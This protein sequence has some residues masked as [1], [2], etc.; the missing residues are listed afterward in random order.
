VAQTNSNVRDLLSL[1]GKVALITGASGHLGSAMA[2]ALAEA[3]ASVV[4]S[5]RRLADAQAAAERLPKIDAKHY[6]AEI[7]HMDESSINSGLAAALQQAGKI[8]VLVN[9]GHEPVADDWSTITGAQFTRQ[10]SNLT[11]YF[12]LA[13][14]IRDH[15]V[16]RGAGGNVVLLGSMYGSVGSYPDVY[17]GVCA[18][19]PAAYQALKGGVAQLT[20]HLAVYWAQD[21][22]R[23][24]CL[25]PGPF[26]SPK[27]P[28]AMIERLKKKSPMGRMGSPQELKGALVFLTSEASS[29]MTGQ[30]L[31]IDGGWTA[32]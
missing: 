28:E 2:S 20:R 10:L 29:Y 27:A 23:V 5:S 11:G 19:N 17:D 21:R 32:W 18:A 4:V 8:D 12:L 25:S 15:L 24:N 26:P 13:R 6:A 16:Q 31:I 22:V 1:D 7:D 14:A 3:G 30:N 9:N